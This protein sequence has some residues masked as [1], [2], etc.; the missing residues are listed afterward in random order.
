M[1]WREKARWFAYWSG[2]GKKVVVA[3]SK[4]SLLPR[5]RYH[6]WSRRGQF[7]FIYFSPAFLILPSLL[8]LCLCSPSFPPCLPPTLPPSLPLPPSLLAS[9][10]PSLPPSLPLTHLQ[11]V[12]TAIA[13]RYSSASLLPPS[14]FSPSSLPSRPLERQ[15]SSITDGSR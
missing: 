4:I 2:K 5:S 14:S 1:R 13:N 7:Q 6:P 10:P 9:L 11:S 12:S 3:G 8:A 15:V